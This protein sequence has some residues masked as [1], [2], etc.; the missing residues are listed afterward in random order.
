LIA[1]S[2]RV[3]GAREPRLFDRAVLNLH[4]FD[5]RALIAAPHGV[6]LVL[7]C[8]RKLFDRIELP[9]KKLAA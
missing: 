3:P 7:N 2:I 6:N 4:A 1:C 8:F 9:E 5:V